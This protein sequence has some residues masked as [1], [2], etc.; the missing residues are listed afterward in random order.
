M[1]RALSSFPLAADHAIRASQEHAVLTLLR[2]LAAKLR[3]DDF[4]LVTDIHL[5]YVAAAGAATEWCGAPR[6]AIPGASAPDF[7]AQPTANRL[8]ALECQVLRTGKALPAH[9]D[10]AIRRDGRSRWFSLAREPVR[11]DNDVYVATVGRSLEAP[12]RAACLRNIARRLP[13]SGKAVSQRVPTIEADKAAQN[14]FGISARVFQ[15]KSRLARAIDL[16][17][18]GADVSAAA[19]SCGY[20]TSSALTRRFQAVAGMAPT[21]FCRLAKQLRAE[22]PRISSAARASAPGPEGSS[23]G[24]TQ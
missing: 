19:A 12:P 22:A 3:G 18:S 5:F 23:A 24:R 9:I 2:P 21:E 4:L 1:Q 20:R 11:L 6:H 7:F 8:M 17:E 16:I 15:T 10:V 14:E 13:D